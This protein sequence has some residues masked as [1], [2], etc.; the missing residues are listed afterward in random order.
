[1][2]TRRSLYKIGG[3]VALLLWCA[4][5]IAPYDI[6]YHGHPPRLEEGG[7]GYVLLLGG[8]LGPLNFSFAWY[9]NLPLLYSIVKLLKGRPSSLWT[10]TITAALAYSAFIPDRTRDWQMEQGAHE[11]FVGPALWYWLAASTVIL[12]MSMGKSEEVAESAVDPPGDIRYA[13]RK[14]P[15]A[16]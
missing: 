9:A 14:F 8:W 13:R 4:S 7:R 6:Q 2:T 12:A 3:L 1:M 10:A 11:S 15:P 5:L 16:S